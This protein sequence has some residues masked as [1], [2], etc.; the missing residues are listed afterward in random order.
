LP[1]NPAWHKSFAHPVKPRISA[2]SQNP[3]KTNHI[4]SQITAPNLPAILPQKRKIEETVRR[5]NSMEESIRKIVRLAPLAEAPKSATKVH[6]SAQNTPGNHL[7][8]QAK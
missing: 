1:E 3:N 6:K 4:N 7:S 2:P 5:A 8:T